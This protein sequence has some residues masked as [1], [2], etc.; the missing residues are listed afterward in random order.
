[1]SKRRL[2]WL[3]A[4]VIGTVIPW[5]FFGRFFA[6]EGFNPIG[7]VAGLFANGAA[8]GFTADVLISL[9]LFWIWS[10]RD[11]SQ[12]GGLWWPV[13]PASALVGLSLA[14]PLYMLLRKEPAHVGN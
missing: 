9:V 2:F 8:G 13:L 3:V 14:F 5:V 11:A 12:S 6:A 7:F 4:C 1:M 10:F